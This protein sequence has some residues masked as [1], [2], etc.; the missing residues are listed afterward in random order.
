MNRGDVM[1][2]HLRVLTRGAFPQRILLRGARRRSNN[3]MRTFRR[4]PVLALLLIGVA[5]AFAASAAAAAGW[6]VQTTP[7]PSSSARLAG[8]S[9]AAKACTAVGDY[10]NH[11]D[12]DVT[13]AEGSNGKRWTIQTTPNPGGSKRVILVGVSCTAA[14]ACT[15]VGYY[16]NDSRSDVTLAERWNGKKWTIQTTPNPT[17]SQFSLVSVS[18]PAAK[19]CIAV[20]QYQ[21]VIKHSAH[22]ALFAERWNG[23]KWTAQLMPTKDY[24]NAGGVSCPATD[25]CTAVGSYSLGGPTGYTLAEYW[26]GRKWTIQSTPSPG[27]GAELVGVSCTASDTCTATGSWEETVSASGQTL[28]E[29]HS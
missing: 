1:M 21:K 2:R 22:E 20:G 19:A 12:N 9:C 4:T 5:S 18:C 25:A 17:G 24:D 16:V 29:R 14:N 11:S 10:V 28:A 27:A 26:N 6:M 15:A 23:K 13:L 3:A 8:V 7:N